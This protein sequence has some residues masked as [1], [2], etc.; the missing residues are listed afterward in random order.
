MKRFALFFA[1]I[2]FSLSS[3]AQINFGVKLGINTYQIEETIDFVTTESPQRN[4]SYAVENE[5]I[6]YH[7]GVYGQLNVAAFIIQPE[8]LFNADNVDYRLVDSNDPNSPD[9]IVSERYLNVDVPILV[10]FK[11]GPARLMLGPVGHF[12]INNS[13]RFRLASLVE[14]QETPIELGYQAGVGVA[15]WKLHIDLKYEGNF[16][17]IGEVNTIYGTEVTFSKNAPR[18]ILSAGYEF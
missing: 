6:G 13:S 3:F 1:S 10:K 5:N 12:F 4:V 18:L 15:F 8:I 9:Q 7:V 16:S 2:L 17:S 11:L 14:A